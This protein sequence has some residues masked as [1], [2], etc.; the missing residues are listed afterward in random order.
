M[1]FILDLEIH[2]KYSRAV[3][4][5]MT[6]ENLAIWAVKK[7]INILGTGDFTHPLW[8]KE[9][10]EK[11]VEKEE[12]LYVL[13][14]EYQKNNLGLDLEKMRF[15]LSSEI[16]CV[17]SKN[18]KVRKVHHLIYAPNIEIAEKINIQLS[19]IGNLKADGRPTLGL[20]SK[21]L[22]DILL[23]TSPDCVLIPAHCWTPWFGIFGS[24][25]G[26]NSLKECFDELESEVFAIETGLSS[27][28]P[29]NWRI[30]FLDEKAIISSSDSHSLKRIGREAIVFDLKEAEINYKKIFEI[31]KNKKEE[32]W[33]TIE[34]FPE[35]GKYHYD[36]HLSCNLSFSPAETKKINGIC[37]KCF[38]PLTIGVMSR[39]EE[40]ADKNRPLGFKPAW[41]KNFYSLI[42]LDEI[43]AESLKLAVSSKK[44]SEKYE[45][46]L[47]NIGSEIY[48]LTQASKEE[49]NKIDPVIKEGILRVREK[50]VFIKPGYDGSYGVIKIFQDEERNEINSQNTLF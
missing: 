46:V 45:E 41:A 16:N 5:Q 27:D 6:L 37:P 22:L 7:G 30:P 38:K 19:W 11:L 8:F 49:L 48:V 44:V 25:S 18:G 42:P 47:N 26:F 36:G 10:K 24:K 34:F 1:R 43:I 40:L 3:S 39:I 35:E 33:G 14:K 15:L 13:K 32:F 23:K 31:I 9:I 50:K 2:S 21:V 20:D 17:Y 12:G 28:P 4:P 29:M